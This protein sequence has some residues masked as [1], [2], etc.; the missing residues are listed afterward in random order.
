MPASGVGG[1]FF[2]PQALARFMCRAER[3]FVEADFVL[4][5]GRAGVF[6]VLLGVLAFDRRPG[7]RLK[8]HRFQRAWAFERFFGARSGFPFELAL[9]AGAGP[10]AFVVGVFAVE[11]GRVSFLDPFD[12]HAA[13]DFRQRRRGAARRERSQR[14]RS[15]DHQHRGPN[16]SHRLQ[17]PSPGPVLLHRRTALVSHFRTSAGYPSPAPA[18]RFLDLIVT[19]IRVGLTQFRFD[20]FPAGRAGEG[21][22]EGA[23]FRARRGARLLVELELLFAG[24][25][26]DRA[27]RE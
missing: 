5:G 20:G 26:R 14:A 3:A 19:R 6:A 9:R 15:H 17:T 7:R 8:R 25:D 21:P 2:G 1:S 4:L 22:A 24:H 12:L 13:A 23:F 27:R 16:Q 18:K 10:G 11:L